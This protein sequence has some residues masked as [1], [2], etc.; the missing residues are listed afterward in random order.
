MKK[1]SEAAFETAIE[2]V[3]LAQGYE[4]HDPKS[5]DRDRAIFPEVALEFIRTTQPK[6][7]NKLEAVHGEQTGERGLE[8]LCKWMDCEYSLAT[9]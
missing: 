9:L 8:A 7:W 3:L 5:F 1:T 6:I 2:D 4:Q